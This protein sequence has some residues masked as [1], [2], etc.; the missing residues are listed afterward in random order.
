[1][2]P[3][4]PDNA[5][6]ALVIACGALVREIRAVWDQF[7][8][9]P[10]ANVSYLPAP[11]H[12][13]PEQIVPA[14]QEQLRAKEGTYSSVLLGYGDCGTGGHLDAFIDR[15]NSKDPSIPM[16]RMSGDHCYEFLTGSNAFAEIHE[17]ELGTFFLTDFIVVN[18]DSLIW[19][20]LG[21]DKHPELR[22]M[23][24]GNYTRALYLAQEPT[25]VR[26]AAAE[27]AAAKLGLRFETH[28]TGFE[29]FREQLVSLARET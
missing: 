3:P 19:R 16:R 9:S 7:P 8:D 6:S 20:G 4:K 18:F 21:M 2:L 24:F 28:T 25:S 23:Y 26:I 27:A 14:I 15:W 17:A 12:N 1:M 10:L 5:E 11:L 13:R 22:D 29:P